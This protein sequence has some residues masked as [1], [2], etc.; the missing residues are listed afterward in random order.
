LS[1][2][3]RGT[4]IR[5][6]QGLVAHVAGDEAFVLRMNRGKERSESAYVFNETGTRLWVMIEGGR[7]ITELVEYLRSE[8]ALSREQAAADAAQFVAELIEEGLVEPA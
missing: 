8:Y 5:R 6:A 2:R 3:Q 1:A 7:N 4:C